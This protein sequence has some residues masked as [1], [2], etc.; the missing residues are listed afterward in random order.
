MIPALGLGFMDVTIRHCCP[1]DY[2]K[3][4]E[5]YNESIQR[6]GITFDEEQFNAVRI[7]RWMSGMN[8][9]EG[10]WVIEHNQVLGWGILK[11]YSDRPAYWRTA[12]SSIYLLDAY[13]GQ[14]YGRQLQTE[15]LSQAQTLQYHHIVAKIVASNQSSIVFHQQFGYEIIGIQKEVGFSKGRWYDVAI[16]QCILSDLAD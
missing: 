15:L 10:L 7:E 14:G 13:R 5:I 16:L 9:R 1:D 3:I 8:D 12:E 11:R 2:E 6:G 4:A